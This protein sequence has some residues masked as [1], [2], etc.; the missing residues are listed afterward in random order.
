MTLRFGALLCLFVVASSSKVTPMEKVIKLL[1]DL[2][3]KVAAEGK[4]EAAAYDKYACFCKEQADE[5][6]YSIEKS[7][8]K[9]V[10][11]QAEIKALDTSIAELNGQI[12]ALAKKISK[13][14]G[15]INR[16]QKVRDGE[17]ADY[18]RDAKDMNE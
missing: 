5:K 10:D 9:I 7:D 14:E 12:G 15:E 1:K 2:S 8:A 18:Q 13:L 3:A 4:E 17:H 11:L 6:L 16:K